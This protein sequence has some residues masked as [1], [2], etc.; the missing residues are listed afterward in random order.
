R[1]EEVAGA[2]L[3]PDLTAHLFPPRDAEALRNAARRERRKSPMTPSQAAR[4]PRKDP[5]RPRGERYLVSAYRLAIYRACDRAFPP[6]PPLAK[7]DDETWKEW[8]G[9]RAPAG[10]RAGGGGRAG[11]RRPAPPTRP[12][13]ATAAPRASDS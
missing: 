11:P 12:A 6:P 3:K 2:W 1:A 7:R 10:P 9:R 13:A 8:R 4:K 5:K